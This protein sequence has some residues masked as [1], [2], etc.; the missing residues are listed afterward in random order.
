MT[1]LGRQTIWN[2]TQNS[3][4]LVCPLQ[5]SP[6]KRQS[7]ETM[8]AT[9]IT[10]WTIVIL[11]Q[12]SQVSMLTTPCL[13]GTRFSQMIL[14]L[15]TLCLS[16]IHPP[17]MF[18]PPKLL[19]SM[20]RTSSVCRSELNG[21]IED[22]TSISTAILSL[23]QHANFERFECHPREESALL[24]FSIRQPPCTGRSFVAPTQAAPS[25][26]RRSDQ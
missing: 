11:I 14:L 13:P 19:R 22:T 26:V 6:R 23:V 16:I 24:R 20:Q 12:A 10:A 9:F 2:N 1:L 18:P 21:V 5:G 15:P 7:L 25:K 8:R 4:C 3:N 17:W